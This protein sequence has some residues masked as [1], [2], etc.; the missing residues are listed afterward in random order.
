MAGALSAA[1]YWAIQED[2]YYERLYGQV[3]VFLEVVV[4][5]AVENR[6]LEVLC[7]DDQLAV[8][9]KEVESKTWEDLS[10]LC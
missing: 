7:L 2:L 4:E 10:G 5:V 1:P 8:E 9:W 3:V 6:R